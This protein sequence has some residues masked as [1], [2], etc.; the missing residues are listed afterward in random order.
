MDDV[1]LE[2]GEKWNTLNRNEQR[3]DYITKIH[4]NYCEFLTNVNCI[5]THRNAGIFQ[6]GTIRF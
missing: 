4:E 6:N 1:V 3:Y 5:L 2:L